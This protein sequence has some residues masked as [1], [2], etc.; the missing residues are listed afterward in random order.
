MAEQTVAEARSVMQFVHVVAMLVDAQ[1]ALELKEGLTHRE[2][3]LA[4][5]EGAACMEWTN[6]CGSCAMPRRL[7]ALRDEGAARPSP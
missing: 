2:V 1:R 7:R 4:N 6:S 3:T 5:G